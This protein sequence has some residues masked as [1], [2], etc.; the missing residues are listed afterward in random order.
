MRRPLTA[1]FMQHVKTV[2][3]HGEEGGV[4]FNPLHHQEDTVLTPEGT[5]VTGQQGGVGAFS[6]SLFPCWFER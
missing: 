4:D 6:M 1:D 2:A 3:E 5:R